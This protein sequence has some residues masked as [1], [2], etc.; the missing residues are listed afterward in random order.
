MTDSKPDDLKVLQA[1]NFVAVFDDRV[2][3]I[4]DWKENNYLRSDRY[5][6]SKYLAIYK[7]ELKLLAQNKDISGIPNGNQRYTQVRL[8][9]VR[10]GKD[11]IAETSSAEVP[12]IIKLFEEINR[13]CKTYYGNKTQ[14]SAC[15]F[16]LDTYGFEKVSRVIKE[17]LPQTNGKEFFP[18][19]TTPVQLKDKWASLDANYRSHISK[20]KSQKEKQGNVY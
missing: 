17:V 3:V 5:T 12:E 19:I 15:Q 4:V 11:T 9:K 6:P 16:L 7:E 14:R 1:K 18:T 20:I 8:G 13:T 10:L 2:L